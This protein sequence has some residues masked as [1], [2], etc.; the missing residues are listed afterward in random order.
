MKHWLRFKAKVRSMAWRGALDRELDREVAAHLVL[1]ADHF[2][3]NGM[4]ADEARKAA[5]RAFGNVDHTKELSATNARSSGWNN[6]SRTC[7][8]PR[9]ACGTIPPSR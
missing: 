3:Q 2:E 8:T 1:L 5:R 7:G 6:S 4:T 9:G